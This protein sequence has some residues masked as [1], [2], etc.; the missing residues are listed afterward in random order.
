MAK[1]KKI[2]A[3]HSKRR[4]AQRYGV[5]INKA[6]RKNL[7]QQIQTNDATFVR[8]HSRRVKEFL[9]QLEGK[10]LRCLYDSQRSTIITFLPPEGSAEAK[11]YEAA[12]EVQ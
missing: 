12:S 10:M 11:E 5:E 7:I 3:I 9:V 4:A 1:T 8:R 6:A 2:L